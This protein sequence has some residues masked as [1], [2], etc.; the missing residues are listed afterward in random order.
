MNCS[1]SVEK[2]KPTEGYLSEDDIKGENLKE[3]VWSDGQN[4]LL[5]LILLHDVAVGWV[6]KVQPAKTQR[7]IYFN[8]DQNLEQWPITIPEWK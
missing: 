4:L 5:F 7:C 2:Y 6:V 1:L 3:E 8:T